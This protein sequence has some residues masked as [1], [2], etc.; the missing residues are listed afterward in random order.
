MTADDAAARHEPYDAWDSLWEEETLSRQSVMTEV[1]PPPP[2]PPAELP[3][4]GEPPPEE[5]PPPP[6]SAEEEYY[7]LHRPPPASALPPMSDN[8]ALSGENLV[9][10]QGPYD[11]ARG[12]MTE[13]MTGGPN[14]WSESVYLMFEN[15]YGWPG[16]VPCRTLLYDWGP[17]AGGVGVLGGPN[18]IGAA[19]PHSSGASTTTTTDI[20]L[21]SSG[22]GRTAS[23]QETSGAPASPNLCEDPRRTSKAEEPTG[24]LKNLSMTT[25]SEGM[26]LSSSFGGSSM[27]GTS[28]GSTSMGG[29]SESA[30][31]GTM[32]AHLAEWHKHLEHHS[33]GVAELNRLT[34][35]LQCPCLIFGSL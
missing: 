34:E 6:P 8:A 3:L 15:S 32:A 27:G 20:T 24:D 28:M 30:L 13:E 16:E 21:L 31:R 35:T 18:N 19:P 2:F 4:L 10:D 12:A 5:I 1:P 17:G 23:T 33:P 11:W 26:N 29:T 25:A 22:K 7:S 14:V 9:L